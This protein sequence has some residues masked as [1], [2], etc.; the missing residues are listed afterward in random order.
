[1]PALALI[2][3]AARSRDF[4]SRKIPKSV[5]P[6]PDIRAVSAPALSSFP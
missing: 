6:L 5:E 2:R 3:D 4:R 1:M